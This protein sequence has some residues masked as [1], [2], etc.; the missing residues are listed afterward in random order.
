M[1]QLEIASNLLRDLP[2]DV[3]DRMEVGRPTDGDCLLARN[4]LLAADCL[5]TE[6][7]RLQ[8]SASTD[9]VGAELMARIETHA[10]VD[11][12]CLDVNDP[13]VWSYLLRHFL[14][15][16]L[17]AKDAELDRHTQELF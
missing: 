5:L 2:S 11:H 9:V 15:L 10:D 8:R 14:K 4:A 1:S 12:G 6:I 13:E 16:G 3:L 17:D 7:E